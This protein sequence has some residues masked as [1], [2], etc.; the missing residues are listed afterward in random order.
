[1]TCPSLR[2]S[3]SSPRHLPAPPPRASF[4]TALEASKCGGS[5]QDP[6]RADAVR[7]AQTCRRRCGRPKVSIHLYSPGQAVDN[8]IHVKDTRSTI[9]NGP[10]NKPPRLTRH[11]NLHVSS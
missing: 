1:M 3:A 4:P 8:Q 6:G 11:H 10:T 2:R 7:C 9:S 5:D